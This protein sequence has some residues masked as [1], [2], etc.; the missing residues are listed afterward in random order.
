MG[1][2]S[3]RVATDDDMHAYAEDIAVFEA[4]QRFKDADKIAARIKN[5]SRETFVVWFVE[6]VHSQSDVEDFFVLHMNINP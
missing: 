5:E 6:H 2:S 4:I 1:A 3:L